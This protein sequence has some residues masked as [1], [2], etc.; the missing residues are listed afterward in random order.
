MRWPPR[1]SASEVPIVAGPLLGEH[2]AEV[3]RDDLGLT[4]GEVEGLRQ[5]GA[6]A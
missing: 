1:M 4:D 3:L 6:I 5:V 2:T